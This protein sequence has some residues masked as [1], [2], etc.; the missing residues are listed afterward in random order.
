MTK[1][2]LQTVS[3]VPKIDSKRVYAGLAAWLW[4]EHDLRCIGALGWEYQCQ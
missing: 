3:I 1:I 4:H 2:T